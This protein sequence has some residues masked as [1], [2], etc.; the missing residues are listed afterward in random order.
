MQDKEGTGVGDWV[1]LRDGSTLTDL[2]RKELGVAIGFD[3]G[4]V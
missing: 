4:T 1:Y 2:V 3:E